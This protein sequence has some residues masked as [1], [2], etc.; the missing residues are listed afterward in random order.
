M[1]NLLRQPAGH[2]QGKPT[3][4]LAMT[5]FIMCALLLSGCGGMEVLSATESP[6]A[7]VPPEKSDDTDSKVMSDTVLIEI[8]ATGIDFLGASGELIDSF[9]FFEDESQEAVQSLTEL[10]E[11][12]PAIAKRDAVKQSRAATDNVWPGFTLRNFG[13]AGATPDQPAFSII[14][15]ASDVNGIAVETNDAIR[16]GATEDEVEEAA[17]TD[18]D[19]GYNKRDLVIYRLDEDLLPEGEVTYLEDGPAAYSISA[20]VFEDEG[21]VSRISAPATNFGK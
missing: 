13:A 16:V 12:K 5:G 17:Y 14:A 19:T 10:F 9:E 6:E 2:A 8:S 4:A 11:E 7:S 15:T 21:V 18:T 20:W 3:I 1:H